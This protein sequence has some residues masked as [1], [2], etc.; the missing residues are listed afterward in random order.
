MT[1]HTKFL[2]IHETLSEAAKSVC[3][4]QD[5]RLII[6]NIIAIVIFPLVNNF[7]LNTI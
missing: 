2:N 5:K 4:H 7:V 1:V 3:V 6:L